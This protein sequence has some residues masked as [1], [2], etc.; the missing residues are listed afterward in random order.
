MYSFHNND[1]ISRVKGKWIIH[2]VFGERNW[3]IGNFDENFIITCPIFRR[4]Q[5]IKAKPLSTI[6]SQ[7]KVFNRLIKNNYPIGCRIMRINVYCGINNSLGSEDFFV[8][9]I[10]LIKRSQIISLQR[11]KKSG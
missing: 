10:G 2:C 7:Q 9:K 11:V 6:F 4:S 3:S 1:T 8:D 5:N